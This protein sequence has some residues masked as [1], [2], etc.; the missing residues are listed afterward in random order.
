MPTQ[1]TQNIHT[2]TI[3]DLTEHGELLMGAESHEIGPDTGA[4]VPDV[5][6]TVPSSAIGHGASSN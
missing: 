4:V 5:A 3:L 2:H 1:R 6:Q